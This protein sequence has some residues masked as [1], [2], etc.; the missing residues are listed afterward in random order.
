MAADSLLVQ[1]PPTQPSPS[2]QTPIKRKQSSL[3]DCFGMSNEKLAK[4]SGECDMQQNSHSKLRKSLSGEALVTFDSHIQE[5]RACRTIVEMSRT[6]K[7]AA[8]ATSTGLVDP[9]LRGRGVARGI[10]KSGRPKGTNRDERT[11]HRHKRDFGGPVLRRDPTA[12]Q[13]LAMIKFCEN[14]VKLQGLQSVNELKGAAARASNTSTASASMECA[15]GQRES[16]CTRPSSPS[17]DSASMACGRAAS[18][19]ITFSL[20]AETRGKVRGS[21]PSARTN[22]P[23]ISLCNSSTS[24]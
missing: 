17:T 21:Q 13:K 19:A 8:R 5:I 2:P 20:E 11:C 10:H 1:D 24:G 23:S 14:M 6:A 7:Q 3:F 4:P 18:E 22:P 9:M 16:L 12:F 15:A